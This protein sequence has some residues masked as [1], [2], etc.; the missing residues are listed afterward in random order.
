MQGNREFVA[1]GLYSLAGFETGPYCARATI[2]VVAGTKV[3]RAND[4]DVP[5]I[6]FDESDSM[7]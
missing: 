6:L 2:I 1:G 7:A 5:G 4:N 3:C